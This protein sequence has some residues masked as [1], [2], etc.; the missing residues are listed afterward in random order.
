MTHHT[1]KAN[2]EKGSSWPLE[3]MKKVLYHPTLL[4]VTQSNR[5][6]PWTHPTTPPSRDSFLRV[7]YYNEIMA[8]IADC[9][10]DCY[11]YNML[12]RL[13]SACIVEHL[14]H[15]NIFLSNKKILQPCQWS[16]ETVNF[17][18]GHAMIGGYS[19]S[20]S[21]IESWVSSLVKCH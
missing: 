19:D 3:A 9:N 4:V 14:T 5:P 8:I 7:I 11:Q 16:L 13:A 15:P 21:R 20:T 17:L 6:T 2:L 18:F 12:Y 1:A 10:I